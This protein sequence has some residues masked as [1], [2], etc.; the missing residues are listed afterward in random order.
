MQR[1]WWLTCLLRSA[2]PAGLLAVVAPFAPAILEWASAR[3]GIHLA[4]A[5]VALGVA[6]M[7]VW[8]RHASVH[9]VLLAAVA[10]L[11][12]CT[13]A[14]LSAQ[15]AD[16]I[17]TI[18]VSGN[19]RLE[20]ET[21]RTYLKFNVGDAYDAGKVDQSIKSLF[22]TG[23]FA[24]V[25]IERDGAAV[26]VT[27]VEN[28]IVAQ[29]AFEGNRE[30]D[31]ATLEGEAQL[32]PRSVFTRARAQADAQRILDVYRRQGRFAASV[33]P[34]LIE[35]ADNRVNLVFEIAEGAA[36]KVKAINFIGN[37]AFSDSQLRD[38]ISTTQSGLFDFLKGTNIYDP[39][40]LMLDR[41]LL[42][43][44]YLKSGY[45]DAQI[46]S[47]GA[48]LDRNGSGFFIT[49]VVDEGVPYKFGAIDLESALPSVNADALR[50]EVLTESGATFD[51]SKLDKTVERLTLAVSEQ[52]VAFARVRPRA[53][54]EPG[55]RV[56]NVRYVIDEGPRIYIERINVIGNVRTRDYVVRREFRLAEGDAYNPLMVDKA[57]KRLQQLGFFK[58]VDIKRRA[59]SAPDHVVLDVEVVEQP[60]G[61]VSF[62]AGYSTSEGVIGDISFTERN[63]LGR[64]QFLRLRVGGSIDRLQVDLGFTE[65]RFLDQN[66]AAGFD[67][68]HKMTSVSDSQP[69]STRTSGGSVRL[70]FPISENLWFNTSYTLSNGEIAD[71]ESTASRA[72]KEAAGQYWTSAIG[73]GLSFDTRNHPKNP[74]SGWFL[75]MGT[76]FAGLGGDVRYVR[77][78]VEARYYYPISDKIVLVGRAIGGHIVGWGGEDVRMLDLY[79]K[80]GETIRGFSRSGLGPRDLLTG[81]ALG[82]TTFWAATAE[83]R[84]PLAF[85]PS[86]IGISSA[87]FVDAGSLYG[88]GASAKA[89]NAKCNEPGTYDSSTGVTT[90]PGVCLANSSA[91]RSSVGVSLIWN[92]P[93]GPLRLDVAKAIKKKSYDDE[94]LIRFGASTRF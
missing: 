60:T 17:G 36:T 4:L 93:L 9:E 54:R 18:E 2:V 65:P 32:K 14:P 1:E 30:V 94:Q 84:F 15:A 85:V 57:K 10:A 19:R 87:V 28:P 8:R 61:E 82:G 42:R 90:Y 74:T 12:V 71:V 72:I 44:Y 75:Q 77:P 39:D 35:L 41:E 53:A 21:V 68:F 80:G 27:V 31:K 46:V 58:A 64:G 6:A 38:I 56:V 33:E 45:A 66:L 24:D 88:A 69:Y 86:D 26:L 79:Y 78:S 40:R 55:A 62:G 70:G 91:W 43:Q 20:P 16:V 34:K 7:S 83:L 47:A 11:A 50:R 81:D 23:L 3:M 73:T 49:F 22:A 52:G 89:L 37:R 59:G 92:S 76:E 5:A 29:V 67:L 48:E 51:Q 63:L 25:R 13:A